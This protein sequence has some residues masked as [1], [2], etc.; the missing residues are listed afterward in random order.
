MGIAFSVNGI[1]KLHRGKPMGVQ[2]H[3]DGNAGHIKPLVLILG[4]AALR[5]G[6][7]AAPQRFRFEGSGLALQH[8]AGGGLDLVGF[9][10]GG[11]EGVEA[12]VFLKKQRHIGSS[13]AIY[14]DCIWATT[15]ASLSQS[16]W[17]STQSPAS[18]CRAMRVSRSFFC[19]SSSRYS[20]LKCFL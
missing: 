3:P 4:E 20:L 5:V 1:G 13:L 2:P 10:R 17:A 6:I 18:S 16:R 8:G 14:A 19:N 12:L 11:V 7:K 9:L 15:A